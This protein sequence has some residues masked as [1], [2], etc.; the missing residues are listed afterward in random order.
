MTDATL[1]IK[2][3]ALGD[4]VL[5]LPLVAALAA[6]GPVDVCGNAAFWDVARQPGGARHVIPFDC[7][8]WSPLFADPPK[9]P[10]RELARLLTRYH[11][12]IAFWR[13]GRRPF[14]RGLEHA[15]VADARVLEPFPVEADTHAA[16]WLL[17]QMGLRDV[18]ATPQV[19]PSE[20]ER[21]AAAEIRNGA[22][23]VVHPGS[24][25]PRK[26][27]PALP[28]V[29]DALAAHTKLPL[30]VSIGPADEQLAARYERHPAVT[31]TREHRMRVL[32]ALLAGA[33]LVVGNDSGITHLAAATGA[34]TVALFGPTDPARWAPR[35][36]RVRILR[37]PGGDWA[38]LRTE[39]V[40]TACLA[41][42]G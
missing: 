9:P 36:P 37:A 20:Q 32:A 34:P 3:G 22:Y 11:R 40:L 8:D 2:P 39:K 17:E 16:D 1:L 29:A 4:T 23:I 28:S 6:E 38:A 35:G 26:N 7:C 30:V 33:D 25:S 13:S 21:A 15:G 31:I 19:I 5:S 27:H 42:R 24:G 41:H 10:G 18:V 12:V 14:A